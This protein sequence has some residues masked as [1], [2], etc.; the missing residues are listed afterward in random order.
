[1]SIGDAMFNLIFAASNLSGKLKNEMNTNSWSD[2][3]NLA[4]TLRRGATLFF[5]FL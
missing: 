2:K 5:F 1:M 4:K 3:E